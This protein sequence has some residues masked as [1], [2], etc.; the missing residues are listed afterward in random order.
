MTEPDFSPT[1]ITHVWRG[2]KRSNLRL[3]VKL[4]DSGPVRETPSHRAIPRPH[5]HR[6][7]WPRQFAM[8]FEDAGDLE[9][10]Q[11]PQQHVLVLA[12]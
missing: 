2:H 10:L 6:P 5:G 9:G 12:A 3:Q 7:A 1:T 4:A 8:A 11:V